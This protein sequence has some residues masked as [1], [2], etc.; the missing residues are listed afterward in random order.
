MDRIELLSSLNLDKF[1]ALDF[2]T[3]GLDFESD[4]II[5]VAAILFVDGLPS[6]RYNTLV[7]PGIP[8]PKL[9]EQITGIT[10][11]MVVNSP[12]E[13][14][15]IDDLFKFIG[16]YP[17]VAHNTPFD[18]S[19]LK[20]IASRHNHDYDEGKYYDTLTL[21]RAFLFFQPAHNLSAISDYYGFSTDGAHRAEY[22]TENCGKI[23]VELIEEAASYKL[24]LISQIISLLQ[25][26]KSHNKDLFIDL[27]NQLTKVGDLKNGLVRSNIIKPINNNYFD[28]KGNSEI[29]NSDSNEIFG[30]G[31]KLSRSFETYEDRQNQVK[32][33]QFVDDIFSSSGGIG[34]AEAGTGLGKSMAYLYPAIKLNS[35]NNGDGPVVISCYTKHLQDQLF[36]K[37]LP[38]LANS[39]DASIQAVVMKGRQNYICK[40]RLD[41]IIA[42]AEKIL[43]DDEVMYLIPLMVW[44][45][46]TLTG[47]MD[48]CPGFTN[49]FTFRIMALIQSEPGFCTSSI[50][51]R[52]GGC[53][54]G[55]LRK[56]VNHANLIVINHALLISESKTRLLNDD[57]LGFLPDYQALIIDEA[58]NITQ[59]AY[60]QLTS[61]LDQNSMLY[62]LDRV[63]P[64]HK[65]SIRWSNQLKSIGGLH[66]Q[67]EEQTKELSHAVSRC[68][69]ALKSFFDQMVSNC[70]HQFNSDAQYSTKL[71]IDDLI[72]EFGSLA[73]ELEL[74][75][76]SYHLV[77]NNIR[78][79][80][81]SLLDIDESKEDFLELHQLLDRGEGF[82]TDTLNLIQIITTNQQ[83]DNVYWYEGSFKRYNGNTQFILSVN[84]S[85]ID[86]AV[87]LASGIF[88]PINYCLLTS[89]TLRTDLSFDYYLQR[90]GL[91]RVEFDDVKMEV[92]E[93]PFHYNDQVNYYQYAGQDGQS[94]EVL[95]KLIYHCHKRH[96]KRMMVLFTSR[97]QLEKTYELIL[98]NSGG[99]DLPIFA[100]KRQTS[101]SGLIRGMHQ[102]SNGILLGTNAFWEGVDFPGD[103]LE[104]LIIVKMPFDVPTEPIVKAFG[105]LIEGQGGNRFM[106]YALPESVIRFRQGF[107][108]L[109]RTSYDE[110]IFIVMDDR[111]VNKRYGKAFSDVIP[112][113][114]KRF[115]DI[116]SVG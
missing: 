57:N 36:N 21:S 55:P 27:G 42:S 28:H 111:I 101:R 50:C 113:D 82:V 35:V 59:A 73:N 98:R 15:I 87:D 8:I 71:I 68:R 114:L 11:E 16:N 44:L 110:G 29:K 4:R 6:K 54:F 106:D 83:Y 33:A 38:R 80:R 26:F 13:K 23:F 94:P 53:F 85:P 100:Q 51:A 25:P 30:P 116:T 76:G 108:R 97:A 7:N 72:N 46:H 96:N 88:K 89:A 1:I 93:S 63:D 39:L 41:W 24:D 34:V 32:Y 61:S 65:H 22:D 58:H 107:G 52:N 92:F 12:K 3:T 67:I 81:E 95:A 9:I 14:N 84:M 79:M 49:G 5:E 62:L 105:D 86:L 91:N 18:L 78:K 99:R 112:V 102:C 77:R 66:P 37:D 60:H 75:N 17:L 40:S 56:M 115:T 10:N 69:D 45:E 2:E 43:N 90:T 19:F 74:L 104:V 47:D 109:I 31:G 70:I 103:L 64:K 48:E 20:S